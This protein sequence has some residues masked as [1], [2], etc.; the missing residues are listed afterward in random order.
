[1]LRRGYEKC[2]PNHAVKK[3]P[4]R[5]PKKNGKS[6]GQ[7]VQAMTTT[8][9]LAPSVAPK[10]KQA[11]RA[12]KATTKSL[13]MS[14]CAAKFALAI[15]DPL[16]PAT[17]GVC[18]PID[19]T[20]SHK[21]AGFARFDVTI[22]TGGYAAVFLCPSIANDCY[23]AIYTNGS[24][25]GTSSTNLQPWAT[26]GTIGSSAATFNTG[27]QMAY[28]NSPYTSQ[29][30]LINAASGLQNISSGKIVAAGL[31]A[32]YVG[33]VLNESGMFTCYHEPTH[34]SL[35]GISAA[36]LYSYAEAS[37]EAIT[38]TPCMLTVYP[39]SDAETQYPE[40]SYDGGANT[41]NLT[42]LFPMCASN[43]FWASALNGA[44]GGNPVNNNPNYTSYIGCPVGVLS[45]TGVPGQVIHM[46]YIAHF[47]YS[48]FCAAA[49]LTSNSSDPVAVKRIIT[50]GLQ[51]PSLKL[52][53]PSVGAWPLMHSIMVGLWKVV[54]PVAV[55]AVERGLVALLL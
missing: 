40:Q 24:Y 4:G 5:Q 18:I 25:T 42:C 10:Q 49:S 16:N 21:V 23:S 13:Q 9:R 41:A 8:Y 12:S 22:G 14:P 44:N 45:L 46:E 6:K 7:T 29:N 47:E 2:I 35:S 28:L 53:Q 38:R 19:G 50:A 20:P 1:M 30:F 3:H 43:S 27:W 48:G 17:R 52:A 11:R 31:R 37:V 15:V 34:G 39:T 32:Q 51:L 33:T 26:Y 55:T 54:K 36:G